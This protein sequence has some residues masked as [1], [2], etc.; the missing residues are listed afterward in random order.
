MQ[1]HAPASKDAPG[2]TPKGPDAVKAS[3]SKGAPSTATSSARAAGKQKPATVSAPPSVATSPAVMLGL[4]GLDDGGNTP[5]SD[6]M[7]SPSLVGDELN[8]ALSSRLDRT[9]ARIDLLAT[10]YAEQQA[11]TMRVETRL[12][13]HIE[14][15][16]ERENGTQAQLSTIL[17]AI[18]GL[19]TLVTARQPA[20]GVR[21]TP[22]PMS[23]ASG[24]PTTPIPMPSARP[25]PEMEEP[26]MS[27]APSADDGR[28]TGDV[29]A[30]HGDS[31]LTTPTPRGVGDYRQASGMHRTGAGMAA[32]LPATNQRTS[33]VDTRRRTSSQRRTPRFDN[34]DSDDGGLRAPSSNYESANSDD[35]DPE[36][37]SNEQNDDSRLRRKHR[38][39]SPTSSENSA[40]F[41]RRMQRDGNWA[42]SEGYPSEEE[43]R[44]KYRLKVREV[45]STSYRFANGYTSRSIPWDEEM[46]IGEQGESLDRSTRT[47]P[48]SRRPS[49]GNELPGAGLPVPR[50]EPM[51]PRF[52]EV[53]MTSELP[54]MDRPAPRREP[55]R[56]RF[57]GVSQ[58]VDLE[59]SPEPA[60]QRVRPRHSVVGTNPAVTMESGPLRSTES[61]QRWETQLIDKYT[62]VIHERIGQPVSKSAR[63]DLAKLAKPKR[64]EPYKGEDDLEILDV[65]INGILRYIQACMATGPELSNEQIIML[66]S[67]VEDHAE[68]FYIDNIVN[69]PLG[70]LTFTE[71]VCMIIQRFITQAAATTATQRFNTVTFN[72]NEGVV[73]YY[74]NLE[75]VANRMV[76]RPDEG[77]FNRRFFD[78]LPAGLRARTMELYEVSADMSTTQECVT[79]AIRVEDAKKQARVSELAST[80]KKEPAPMGHGSR[81]STTKVGERKFSSSKTKRSFIKNDNDNYREQRVSVATAPSKTGADTKVR[82]TTERSNSNNCFICGQPGHYA[83]NCPQDKGH[84]RLNAI[85]LELGLNA[86]DVDDDDD[87]HNESENHPGEEPDDDYLV[88][89]IVDVYA[90]NSEDDLALGSV[91]L[92]EELGTMAETQSGTEELGI[93]LRKLTDEESKLDLDNGDD[94]VLVEQLSNQAKANYAAGPK[95]Y[96]Q[97]PSSSKATYGGSNGKTETKVP[98]L[99]DGNLKLSAKV[100]LQPKRDVEARRAIIADLKIGGTKALVLF[101]SGSDTDALSPDFVRAC[102]IPVFKLDRSIPIQLGTKGSRSIIHYGTN[103]TVAFGSQLLD[104]Y[105]DILNLDKYDAIIGT[106]WLNKYNATLDFN[107]KCVR[108]NGE[109]VEALPARRPHYQSVKAG[110]KQVVTTQT[111]Q[112]AR[113][114][115]VIKN[116]TE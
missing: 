106:P 110:Y 10:R 94:V 83:R 48:S 85:K 35:G 104:Q 87:S 9:T 69:R 115:D 3:G 67:C 13:A 27:E 38:F 88:E 105:F 108:M 112:V 7:S 76:K 5:L 82:V 17:A 113:G 6:R 43:Q 12:E 70:Q 24:V 18:Q 60:A 58:V 29:P 89:P 42:Y 66:G 8:E 61:R 73:H 28:R 30:N 4:T 95:K 20:I 92:H 49:S 75:R 116:P 15:S 101:D 44:R 62:F 37:P 50:R 84:T 31:P 47:R 100:E 32:G 56:P 68:A 54:V 91:Y 1:N 107:K 23:P 78:G 97:G 36:D 55:I 21:T 93:G 109:S 77:T 53:S 98:V 41:N 57:S 111:Q 99:Y 102:G 96:Y 59:Y 63:L 14:R 103:T 26:S 52:S 72:T 80:T 22:I 46:A 2:K 74:N 16:N 79:A 25:L 11:V 33:F 34:G 71:A 64:P 90:S 45:A 86:L 39:Q 51:R 81:T 19:T 114:Q 65:W 40:A